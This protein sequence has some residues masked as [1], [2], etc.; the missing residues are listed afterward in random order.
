[1]MAMTINVMKYSIQLIKII[2]VCLVFLPVSSFALI[3]NTSWDSIELDKS[4]RY[5]RLPNGFTYYIKPSKHNDKIELKYYVK[6][7]YYNEL[8][9]EFNF[10]HLI[11]HIAGNE[12]KQKAYSKNDMYYQN[13]KNDFGATTGDIKTIY[14]GS[15][16][17][18]DPVTLR[19]RLQWFAEISNLKMEDCI[20][21]Q[22]ARCVRQEFFFRAQ[23]LALNRAFNKSVFKSAI[24]F[25]KNGEAPYSN[26][27]STYDMGGINIQ[28]VHDFYQR[29]YQPQQM[30]LVI[31]GN[32][33]DI[34][35]LEQQII[36]IY[37][38][39]PKA[40]DK[41]EPSDIRQSYLVASPRFKT[42][43]RKEVN[44]FTSWNNK[45][46][47]L[48]L[49][50][51]VKRFHIKLDTKDKW[52][53]RQ[54]YT[55]MYHMIDSR[56]SR[57]IK[58]V[59]PLHSEIEKYQLALANYHVEL[60]NNFGYEHQNIKLV[61]S[62][63]QHL[64]KN[65]FTQ[66]EWNKQKQRMLN[67]IIKKD[68]S[69]SRYWE[70]EIRNNFVFGEI[71]PAQKTVI[72]KQWIDSLSLNDIN[73]YLKDNFSA[74]PDDIFIMA[75]E[76]H[77]ALSLTEK[78][79]REMIKEIIKNPIKLKEINDIST[80]TSLNKI[81]SSLMSAR[82][83]ANLKK[84]GYRKAGIDP[85]TGMEVLELANG[86]KIILDQK[87]P[88]SDSSQS[89]SVKGTC[90]KG[91]SSFPKNSYYEAISATEIVKLSGAGGF[92]R[93]EIHRKIGKSFLHNSEPVHINIK[94]NS[95]TVSAISR[96]GELETYLQ[97]IYLYFTSPNKDSLAFE[98]WH[99]QTRQ[100]YLNEIDPVNPNTDLKNAIADYLEIPFFKSPTFLMSTEQF[101]QKQ[102]VNYD[103][104]MK[105]YHTIFGN[106]SDF[107]FVVSGRYEKERVLTL[108]KKYL[109]NLP[110]SVQTSSTAKKASDSG[111]FKVPKG[112][113][114]HTF[115]ADI[116]NTAYKLYTTPYALTYVFAIP[117]DNWKDRVVLNLIETYI[118][119]MVNNEL[120]YIKNGSFYST[121]TTAIYSEKQSLYNFTIYVESLDDEL[122][123]I[124]SECNSLIKEIKNKGI[125]KRV[126]TRILADPLF[127]DRYESN[128]SLKA[129][130]VHYAR[131]LTSIDFKKVAS[132]YFNKNHQYEFVFREN[133]KNIM[134][135]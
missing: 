127:L 124:R 6:V 63:L 2:L 83:V 122:E 131:S 65:G 48:S 82:E 81:N 121:S 40:K 109:G 88:N 111:Y 24:L 29:W 95:S 1:M 51:R 14:Y 37:N 10:S 12:I 89:I 22:E 92:S 69:T 57:Y 68:T 35:S 9:S 25:D 4:I 74:M 110:A 80:L 20:V 84:V 126:I 53:N 123:W 26:W 112:P 93:D 42:V 120:R 46:S 13:R 11:E 117:K 97:L 113:I 56:L 15:I 45:H 119:P 135:P 43:E 94:P 76:G 21:V 49:L 134:I 78:Q 133:E 107:T 132:K 31:T 128:P 54:L 71:L 58:A 55:A 17:G 75:S 59:I 105:Y 118:Q 47:K 27:L 38:K 16:S 39:I 98:Q 32:I 70:K 18:N 7:G 50:Y 108:L 87:E 62:A 72:T 73:S 115:Y 90:P 30:G 3:G 96:L 125:A 5:G 44:R 101:Y 106:A 104:A 130:V 77:P 99:T 100:R 28:E 79:V 85:N 8:F 19:N 60:E 114:Y 36:S 34:N 52:L 129:K 102:N 64:I 103:T 23:G 86:V 61:T 33:K 41:I 91:A 66:L 116:M 67:N